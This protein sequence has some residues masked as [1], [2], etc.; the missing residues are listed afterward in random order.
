MEQQAISQERWQAASEGT[1]AL[2][3]EHHE[4][5]TG[6]FGLFTPVC[7]MPEV[8]ASAV[9]GADGAEY[10]VTSFRGEDGEVHHEIAAR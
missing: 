2:W 9:R 8:A 3:V 4:F 5:L 6:A 7:R 1:R 10:W